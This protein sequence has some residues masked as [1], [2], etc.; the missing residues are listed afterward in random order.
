MKYEKIP[1]TK[2]IWPELEKELNPFS[3]LIFQ[4][5]ND[6]ITFQLHRKRNSFNFS[7]AVYINGVMKGGE[8]KENIEKYWRVIRKPL[9]STTFKKKMTKGLCKKN[10]KEYIEKFGLDKKIEYHIPY[11]DTFA[12]LKIKYKALNPVWLKPVY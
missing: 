4:V 12:Q 11:F 3:S 7:I 5:D 6:E 10:S 2:E 1:V 8:T 9:H